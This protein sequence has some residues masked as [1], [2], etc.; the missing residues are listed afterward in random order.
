MS[1]ELA[2]CLDGADADYWAYVKLNGGRLR[3]AVWTARRDVFDLAAKNK[4]NA[5]ERCK[6][7][8]K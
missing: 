1:Q 3:G 5:V 2:V 7:E 6:A 8:W 4:A